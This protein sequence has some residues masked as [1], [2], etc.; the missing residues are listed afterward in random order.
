MLHTC[1]KQRG[2]T[3]SY[4]EITLR[5]YLTN[6]SHIWDLQRAF[7]LFQLFVLLHNLISYSMDQSP[8]WE[9]NQFAASQEI[10]C[11][12]WN[13]NIHY[14]I[15]KCPPPV[16]ILSQLDLVH[17][18]TSWRFILTLSSHLCLGLPNGLL[19]SGV[20]TKTLYMPLLYP[21]CATSPTHLTLLKFTT[22]TI[23]G[24]GHWSLSSSLLHN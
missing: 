11:I 13:P 15:H 20:L 8:S 9:A 6:T 3:V 2:L 1:S 4:P 24:D 7:L 19:P 10:P 16:P 14:H 5:L 17:T 22:Q 12:L 21:M 23:L 18:P